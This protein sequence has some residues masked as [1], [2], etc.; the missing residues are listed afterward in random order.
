MNIHLLQVLNRFSISARIY[1]IV[2]LTVVSVMI[3]GGVYFFGESSM[4][5]SIKRQ[6]QYALLSHMVQEVKNGALQMR[7][8]E[9]DFLLRHDVKYA[10]KYTKAA[11]K[12]TH[13]LDEM[14][15][16]HAADKVGEHIQHLKDSIPLHQAEFQKVFNLY[17]EKGL[18]EKLGLQGELRKA[19]HDVEEKLKTAKLD[20]LT[21]KMLMMRRHEKD[22][23]LRGKKKYIGRIDK[24]REE[25]N[26][27]L[28]E[29]HL[30]GEM[31]QEI[32][33]LMDV[34]QSV[35]KSFAEKRLSLQTEIKKLSS[36]FSEMTPAFESIFKYSKAG[37]QEAEASLAATKHL[38]ETIFISSAIIVLLTA[39]GLGILIGYSITSP[40]K[41]LTSVMLRL[42]DGDTSAEV[43]CGKAS[44][45]IGEIALAVGVF[46][47][48]ALK[49]EKLEAKQ[50]EMKRQAEEEKHAMMQKMANDFDSNIGGIV[51][52][53]SSA[54]TELQA[55]AESMARI[56]EQTSSEATAV[57]AASQRT[58]GNVQSVASATEEM[59]STISEISQQVAQ[60][61]SASRQAVEEV[62][63]T[64]QQMSSLA[65][66]ADKIS[67]VVEMISSIAEQTN[68]LALNATIESAR[69]GE[70]GK[71]FAV[72]ANEVK[73][74]ASQ[75]AKATSEISQQIGDIQV[76]TKQA[77]GSMENV[78]EAIGRVD[79]I[80]TA[81]AA[82]ME[83]QI[84]A[85]QEIASSVNQAAVGTKQVNESITSV[86]EASQEAGAA[87]N[88]VM[89]AAGELSQQS[90][91]LKGEVDK[92]IT[93]IRAA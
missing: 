67:E 89:S 87:S 49:N 66:T 69:A 34:Y 54:S 82:A 21:I 8:R 83:E 37:E 46:K 92:F 77:S 65:G 64:G 12:V 78:S 63:N 26:V 90:E 68:L 14:S 18:N 48:N 9:K 50:I 72:V 25:F 84:A 47:E 22:F 53:V 3:L 74:L 88:Q 39:V 17:K 91:L 75:T 35:F 57:S 6:S 30:S 61:S 1:L 15:R 10:K 27:L 62:N 81:I 41:I 23:M 59:T 11:E 76:A 52:T 42:A 71:G 43:P 86:T 45:E 4:S 7:R 51:G 16:L 33:G 28:K 79:E 5:A 24:R 73:E 19:V 93:Q 85:T 29:S 60:A 58:S 31:Q 56:S 2:S 20:G 36:V 40:L 80:S 70:A 13:A 38:T 55:T 44:S 32:S